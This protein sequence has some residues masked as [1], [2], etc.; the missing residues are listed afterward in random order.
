M[1]SQRP[2]Q[3]P[4]IANLEDG[5]PTN[6]ATSDFDSPPLLAGSFNNWEYSPMMKYEEFIM[7]FDKD[8]EDPFDDLKRKESIAPEAQSWKDL[9]TNELAHYIKH[10]TK[11][12]DNYKKNFLSM[13]SSSRMPYKDPCLINFQQF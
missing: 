12:M 10:R 4:K 9:D 2:N 8:F 11:M 3:L 5:S 1:I 13:L 7:M 6:E